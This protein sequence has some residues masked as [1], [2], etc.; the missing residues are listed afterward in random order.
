VP[1]LPAELGARIE[2]VDWTP[3]RIETLVRRMPKVESHLHLD[4]SLSPATVLRLAR[5]QRYAPLESLTLDEIRHRTVVEQPRPSLA[6]VLAVFGTVYPLLRSAEALETVAFELAAS[7]ASQDT[8]Y[9]E[10]RFAP[11][12]QAA[13]GFGQEAALDA[14]LEGLA[15]GRREHGVE[16]AVILCLIRPDALV[17]MAANR[18]TL[19]L[20]LD[21]RG[22]GVVAIDL[23][24]DEA[25][26]PLAA[27]AELFRRARRGGLALTAHA[28]EAPGGGDL[29]TAL[30]L[31]VDRLGHGTDLARRPELLAEVL[32]RRIPIEVNLTSNLRTG[33]VAA[34]REH[35]VRDWFRA[36]AR[37]ALG[38]DDPG[39]F[40][41]DLA[42]EY[43]LLHRE[44][45]F[46][47]AELV[48]VALQGVDALFLPRGARRRMRREFERELG[49]LLDELGGEAAPALSPTR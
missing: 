27:Y 23:A 21:R 39:V 34:V 44:L 26:A 20:A 36:G 17:S 3:A 43:L 8:R 18:A 19:E 2:R 41:N 37:I 24:G 7:A 35:P 29:E 40:G 4:G 30:E 10:V 22:R 25:A 42:G 12:L 9:V 5:E 11:A 28:G 31:G 48:A 38:T 46:T 33:A 45:G 16:S 47:P 15:R 49:R 14:V 13:P 1:V 6:E 32:R